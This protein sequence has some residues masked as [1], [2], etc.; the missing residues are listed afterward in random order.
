MLKGVI[1]SEIDSCNGPIK[2]VYFVMPCSKYVCM[3][4]VHTLD[5]LQLLNCS[6]IV[7]SFHLIFHIHRNM[8]C[9]SSNQTVS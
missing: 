2:L 3:H 9:K 7:D 1:L 4:D 6:Y 5:C 8:N